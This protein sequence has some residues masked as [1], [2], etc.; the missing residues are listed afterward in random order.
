[1]INKMP[2]GRTGHM[3]S[4]VIFGAAA[5]G[6]VT[7]KEAD[8]TYDLLKKYDIN[9]IDV[10]QSYGNA[11]VRIGPW[12]K[13][14]RDSFFLA[15]KTDKRTKKEAKEELYQ[16]LEKLKTDYVDLW[17]FHCLIDENEWEIAMGKSG[18]LEAA[19]DAKKQGLI[20]NIGVTGHG[21]NAAAMHYKSLMRYDFDSVLFPYN[22]SMMQNDKYR[23]DVNKLINLCIEKNVAI[24]TIK[25]LSKGPVKDDDNPFATWYKPLTD[26]FSIS[27][28]VNWVLN[29]PNVF[30]NSTGDITILPILLEKASESRIEV[31]ESE[32]KLLMKEYNIEALFT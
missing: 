26:S 28:S 15:T 6:E 17:Q 3:S 11:E 24:Q 9:H 13:K 25:S 23:E 7:Q 2:F 16:S 21:I 14:D 22:Y 27:K 19:I 12:M 10:A 30:L 5:L 32:M 1:M 4:R 20:K 29:N 31:S 8:Q 18:V